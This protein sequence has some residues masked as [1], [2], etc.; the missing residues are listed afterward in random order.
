MVITKEKSFEIKSSCQSGPEQYQELTQ[1][2][3]DI[4]V[5]G[6]VNQARAIALAPTDGA[7]GAL[8][9]ARTLMP[10]SDD[11]RIAETRL[12]NEHEIT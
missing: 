12:R 11:L 5:A 6:T 2:K 4:A 10:L 1:L 9:N 7:I 3:H 8:K